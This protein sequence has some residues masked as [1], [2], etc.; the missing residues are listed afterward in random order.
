MYDFIYYS[1]YK[2]FLHRLFETPVVLRPAKVTRAEKAKSASV[3]FDEDGASR[4]AGRPSED[5]VSVTSTD[6]QMSAPLNLDSTTTP[7]ESPGF[8]QF[9]NFAQC[10]EF[11][12]RRI[13]RPD[14]GR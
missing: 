4:G 1:V 11:P 10:P 14:A 2:Q 9:P 3:S 6:W 13:L 7:P 12:R 5:T 8:P